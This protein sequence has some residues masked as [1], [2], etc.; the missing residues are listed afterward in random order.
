M[1]IKVYTN[2]LI[3]DLVGF[4]F[5][6]VEKMLDYQINQG[7]KI[8]ITVFQNNRNDARNGFCWENTIEGQEFWD[9]VIRM[10]RFDRFF[11]RYKK[12]KEVYIRGDVKNGENVIKELESRGGINTWGCTGN[13]NALYYID[14]DTN[15]I[16]T[17]DPQYQNLLTYNYREISPCDIIVEL[18]ME[19][20]AE[21]LGVDVNRLRI[22]K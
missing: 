3:G 21:K 20:I 10:K 1:K 5:E 12:S 16:E 19:E 4:P 17:I 14:P 18:T 6:V 22:K 8:D 9:N 2:D 13:S 11:E 7:N 15:N